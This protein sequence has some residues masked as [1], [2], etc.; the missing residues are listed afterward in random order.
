ME[1]GS[2]TGIKPKGPPVHKCLFLPESPASFSCPV[3]G[4][5]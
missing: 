5:K 1:E 3:K 2:S 4:K